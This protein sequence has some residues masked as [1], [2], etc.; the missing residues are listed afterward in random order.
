[1]NNQ[2]KI[3]IQYSMYSSI[4]IY[5]QCI[6]VQHLN[7]FVTF[8]TYKR[9]ITRTFL[10]LSQQTNNRCTYIQLLII[11]VCLISSLLYFYSLHTFLITCIYIYR[12]AYIHQQ[13]FLSPLS[14]SLLVSP[15][16]AMTTKQVRRAVC[17]DV[18][19]LALTR[20]LICIS[21][22]HQQRQLFPVHIWYFSRLIFFSFFRQLYL[23]TFRRLTAR[24]S[25]CVY[26]VQTSMQICRKRRCK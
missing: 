23:I 7:I 16:T 17:L 25:S 2:F 5:T 4:Y 9:T 11:K 14:F 13:P 19:A 10:T 12:H 1:M 26:I 18:C 8:Q 20:A 21:T 22:N 6:I 15:T 3:C 24:S